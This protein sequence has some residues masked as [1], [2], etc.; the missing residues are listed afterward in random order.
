LAS[1]CF[2]VL[3]VC[4]IHLCCAGIQNGVVLLADMG[5]ASSSSATAVVL[6][7][8]HLLCSVIHTSHQL[9]L[10]LLSLSAHLSPLP[11]GATACTAA[12]PIYT[13]KFG[14]LDPCAAWPQF[15]YPPCGVFLKI[16]RRQPVSAAGNFDIGVDMI[17]SNDTTC[18]SRRRSSSRR[19][20]QDT[21]MLGSE[22][23]IVTTN[24]TPF[25]TTAPLVTYTPDG[26]TI[27]T[28]TPI[29]M[30]TPTV[31]TP[32]VGSDGTPTVDTPIVISP[33]TVDTSEPPIEDTPNDTTEPIRPP[34]VYNGGDCIVNMKNVPAA[35]PC[36]CFKGQLATKISKRR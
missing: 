27:I 7:L 2:G 24:E 29:A 1:V 11:A 8:L 35:G 18:A 13:G 33:P 17:T 23:P 25:L 10:L 4:R 31:F 16:P 15:N 22:N 5:A 3:L 26:S 28:T 20:L 36:T 19:L 34:V 30:E 21:P 32:M 6:L 12:T 9:L 14:T